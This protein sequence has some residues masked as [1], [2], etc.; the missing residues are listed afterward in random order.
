MALEALELAT[1]VWLPKLRQQMRRRKYQQPGFGRPPALGARQSSHGDATVLRHVHVPLAGHVL[2][3]VLRA[4]QPTINPWH[5]PKQH[6]HSAWG[7]TA[8]PSAT[9]KRRKLWPRAPQPQAIRVFLAAVVETLMPCRQ[10]RI[11]PSHLGEPRVAE[12]AD[13]L[14]DVLPVAG[15]ADLA[16]RLVQLQP[17]RHDAIRHALQFHLHIQRGVAICPSA[18]RGALHHH[19]HA[20]SSCRTLQLCIRRPRGLTRHSE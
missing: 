8:P 5:S 18:R 20:M 16:Q 9:R 10:E 7:A 17:H 11:S 13:L 19:V 3:L 1:R 6:N 14:Q 4:S 15:R 12:H 2:H